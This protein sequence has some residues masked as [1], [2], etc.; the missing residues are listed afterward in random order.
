MKTGK[1]RRAD[2][3]LLGQVGYTKYVRLG[4]N[5]PP[6]LGVKIVKIQENAEKKS[7]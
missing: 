7:L 2:Q 5:P 4:K 1:N 6:P 3:T